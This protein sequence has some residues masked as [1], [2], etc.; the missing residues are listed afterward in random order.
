MDDDEMDGNG[1]TGGTDYAKAI[2]T[3]LAH[4]MLVADVKENIVPLQVEDHGKTLT[5]PVVMLPDGPGKMKAKPLLGDTRE[6]LAMLREKRLADA[7]GPD[8]RTGTAIHQAL[9]SLI[10]H[11][12]RFKVNGSSV[13][14]ANEAQRQIVAI[15]DYHY[16]TTGADADIKDVTR[17]GRHRGVYDCPLSE[18]WKAWG[19][20]KPMTIGQDQLIAL[21]DTRDRELAVGDLPDGSP[22]PTPAALLTMAASLETFEDKKIKRERD[23]KTGK[24]VLKF[25][26]ESGFVGDVTPP[27]SFLIQIPVFQDGENEALEVRLRFSVDD[28]IAKFTVQIHAAETVLRDAFRVL[29]DRVAKG[30][31]LPVFTGVSEQ[32]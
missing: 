30:T 26:N 11:V 31:G 22:A 28:A 32:E 6:A 5:I 23:Q 8:F 24:A 13:V 20:G 27:S 15:L 17:W 1:K 2:E 21:L 25:S 12:N 14:W 10:A 18:A 16:G 9:E 7:E 3:L 29:V 4:G 19:G